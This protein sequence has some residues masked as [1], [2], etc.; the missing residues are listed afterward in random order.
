M[1]CVCIACPY[2]LVAHVRCLRVC[3]ACPIDVHRA[4]RACLD[5][6]RAARACL[7]AHR[8]ARAR[9]TSVRAGIANEALMGGVAS[10]TP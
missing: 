9:I 2:A 1:H 4:A 5:V 10:C 8:A 6:H 7:D 3:V